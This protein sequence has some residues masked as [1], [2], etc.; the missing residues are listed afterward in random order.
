MCVCVCVL[1]LYIRL[2]IRVTRSYTRFADVYRLFSMTSAFGFRYANETSFSFE[3]SCSVCLRAASDDDLSGMMLCD[4]G[5]RR[6]FHVA[7]VG[8]SALPDTSTSSKWACSSCISRVR[9][10]H[11]CTYPDPLSRLAKCSVPHCGKAYHPECLAARYPGHH[12]SICP[13]HVCRV[14]GCTKEINDESYFCI[15]CLSAFHLKCLPEEI[16]VVCENVCVCTSHHWAAGKAAS[17]ALER[18]SCVNHASLEDGKSAQSAPVEAETTSSTPAVSPKS[19]INNAWVARTFRQPFSLASNNAFCLQSAETGHD[20]SGLEFVRL[21]R[22]EWLC[23]RRRV[24]DVEEDSSGVCGCVGSCDEHCPN[25]VCMTSCTWSNCGL[26]NFQKRAGNSAYRAFSCGNKPFVNSRS[27]SLYK[28][29]AAG[30]KGVGLVAKRAIVP[31]TFIVEYIG[32]VLSTDQWCDRQ[33]L[34]PPNSMK[35]FYVMELGPDLLIDAS[36]KGNDSRLINHSC[37][38]NLETQKWTVDGE[39]RV[40]L[41]AIKKISPGDELTFNYQFETFAQKPVK[42]LCGTEACLGWIGGKSQASRSV[43]IE[44]PFVLL[45]QRSCVDIRLANVRADGTR[46]SDA[47]LEQEE[48]AVFNERVNWGLQYVWAGSLSGEEWVR[49]GRICASSPPVHSCLEFNPAAI[50]AL[51]VTKVE[52]HF[53]NERKLFVL[54]NL[55]KCRRDF[56]RNFYFWPETIPGVE[57]VLEANLISDDVCVRCRRSGQL[58]WCKS[59]VRSFHQCCISSSDKFVRDPVPGGDAHKFTCRRCIRVGPENVPIKQTAVQRENI[60]KLR[61]KN[62]WETL[63]LPALLNREVFKNSHKRRRV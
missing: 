32:E 15:L 10:C 25:V 11:I 23:P 19:V 38:P 40:G 16:P 46:K 63:I 5:C 31:G 42:C 22:N 47:E 28:V 56:A 43:V 29:H 24:R 51:S 27:N 44:T 6:I 52:E 35:H 12:P 62:R 54:R 13:I 58:L 59:C 1:Y 17:S 34:E 3:Y 8:L 60:C 53:M 48:F 55:R 9:T 57:R 45:E 37:D 21:R 4:G 20:T 39:S 26:T 2:Y 41:F 18:L 7:C 36:R 61:R 30:G 14:P 33:K 49:R 50:L